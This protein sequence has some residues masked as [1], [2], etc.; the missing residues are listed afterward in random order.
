[1]GKI[2]AK[3]LNNKLVKYLEDNQILKE[4]QHGFRKKRGTSTLLANLYERIAREKGTDRK[5]LITL[6][7]RDVKKAFDKV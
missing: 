1:M 3:I 6:V 7:T 5:T 4:T 2:F